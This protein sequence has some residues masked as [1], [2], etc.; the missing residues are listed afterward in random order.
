MPERPFLGDVGA[1]RA[2]AV[3]QPDRTIGEAPPPTAPS[4]PDPSSPQYGVFVDHA[5]VLRRSDG[6]ALGGTSGGVI[7]DSVEHKPDAPLGTTDTG[8]PYAVTGTGTFRIAS[9]G[10]TISYAGTAPSTAYL[11]AVADAPIRRMF[12]DAAFGGG[13]TAGGI[14]IIAWAESLIGAGA[15]HNS[16]AHVLINKTGW[17]WQL[18]RTDGDGDV[19]IPVVAQGAWDAGYVWDDFTYRRVGWWA[20]DGWGVLLGPDGKTYRV[21]DERIGEHPGRYACLEDNRT[22]ST[23]RFLSIRSWGADTDLRS[24]VEEAPHA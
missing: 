8:Q 9:G 13:T 4:P 22:A 18:V 10:V 3:T 6:L 24:H 16:D 7:R 11:E 15:V 17:T 21:D 1:A 2:A 20:G 19:S 5:G 23:D 14:A 12:A